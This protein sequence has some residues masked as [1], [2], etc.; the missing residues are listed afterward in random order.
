MRVDTDESISL[1]LSCSA[2]DIL[3]KMLKTI[4]ENDNGNKH[5]HWNLIIESF[6]LSGRTIPRSY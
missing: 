3:F 6:H 1:L 5:Y 2:P 4:E